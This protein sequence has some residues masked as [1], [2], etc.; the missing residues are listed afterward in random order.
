MQFI[1]DH[2]GFSAAHISSTPG[3]DF[4]PQCQLCPTA[5]AYP[6]VS[7]IS[8]PRLSSLMLGGYQLSIVQPAGERGSSF[9]GRDSL[10]LFLWR[11][12]DGMD[13]A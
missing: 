2:H 3:R 7:D 10:G 13:G 12:A 5:R 8:L 4:D 1:V 11:S 6:E 9:N